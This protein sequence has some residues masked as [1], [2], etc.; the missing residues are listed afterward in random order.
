M[1]VNSGVQFALIAEDDLQKSEDNLQ[2]LG[3]CARIQ[4]IN[5]AFRL[6]SG[7]IIP[8]K[9][10][11]HVIAL[12]KSQEIRGTLFIVPVGHNTILD[13]IWIRKLEISSADI[14]RERTSPRRSGKPR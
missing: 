11:I 6:Y 5:L 14:D 1:E 7:N 13:H 4:P 12:Y 10:E 2:K 9:G 8:A 3:I